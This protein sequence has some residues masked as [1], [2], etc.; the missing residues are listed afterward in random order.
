MIFITL[1]IPKPYNTGSCA[2]VTLVKDNKV[3]TAN[4]G[5]CKGVIISEG[6]GHKFKARKIN[7][8]L[9]ATSLKEQARLKKEFP[10]D[11]DIVVNRGGLPGAWY[12]KGRLM[13]TSAFGDYHLKYAEYF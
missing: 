3:F 6:E 7:H 1:E 9:N 5:D 8:K 4:L 2:L 11:P 10:N 13:P 12:V